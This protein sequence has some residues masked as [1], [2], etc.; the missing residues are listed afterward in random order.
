MRG[1]PSHCFPTL[2]FP[3]DNT[4][5][6]PYDTFFNGNVLM[7]IEADT[8]P[9][10]RDYLVSAVEKGK[11]DAEV[12]AQYDALWEKKHQREEKKKP[13]RKPKK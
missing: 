6:R 1:F 13:G 7:Q 11:V 2:M 9:L 10:H 8:Y 12:L 4:G 5:S 3:L